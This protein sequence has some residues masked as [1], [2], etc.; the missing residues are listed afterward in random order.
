MIL[1]HPTAEGVTPIN[2]SPGYPNVAPSLSRACE[3][4]CF[5]LCYNFEELAC[6]PRKPKVASSIP[7]GVSR[8]SGSGNRRHSWIFTALIG[9]PYSLT[10]TIWSLPGIFLEEQLHF[11]P[12][13]TR[14][15]KTHATVVVL[16]ATSVPRLPPVQ[17]TVKPCD[18]SRFERVP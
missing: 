17:H 10:L 8:F 13:T 2:L 3:T 15:L 11:S 5:R 1:L 18:L 16:T 12:I 7:V 4:Q 9:Q 6:P 14:E